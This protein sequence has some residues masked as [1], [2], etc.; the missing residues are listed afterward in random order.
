MEFLRI[1]YG[2]IYYIFKFIPNKN[3]HII[4]CGFFNTVFTGV[5]QGFSINYYLKIHVHVYKLV[6]L[7]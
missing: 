1:S 6:V 2:Y 3:I 5:F 4:H 7:L